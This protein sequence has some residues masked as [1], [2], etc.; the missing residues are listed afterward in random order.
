MHFGEPAVICLVS[1]QIWASPG[2]N[3]AGAD[4]HR[5]HSR[6]AFAPNASLPV[7]LLS[8]TH[9]KEVRNTDLER[10]RREALLCGRQIQVLSNSCGA[11]R[12]HEGTRA[13]C[14]CAWPPV[15]L[16]EDAAS[17]YPST[18]FTGQLSLN[19]TPLPHRVQLDCHPG[20]RRGAAPRLSLSLSLSCPLFFLPPSL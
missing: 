1:S 8:P 16:T 20:P 12:A 4:A 15:T 18:G 19:S 3:E 13:A 7:P 17:G 11:F 2:R 6:C 10:V 5:R 14:C 9:G